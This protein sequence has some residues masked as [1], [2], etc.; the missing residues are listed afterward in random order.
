MISGKMR[1][2]LIGAG[3]IA[4]TY[5]Q[6]FAQSNT[7][8]LVGVVDVREDAA[9]T[10]AERMHC[11]A[12]SSYE[13]MCAATGCE[14]AIVS[15]PPVTHPEICCWLLDRDIHVL[16]EKP[17]AIGPTEAQAMVAAAEQSQATLKMASKFRHVSDVVEAKAIV[18]SGIIGDI[19]LFENAFTSRVDMSSRW[20]SDPTVAGGGV[21]IDN[22]TH[23]VDIMRYFLGPIVEIQVVEG[24]RVQDIPV[25]DTVRVFVR[26]AAGAMGTIDLSWSLNKEL[27]YYLSIYGSSGTLHVGWKESKFRRA[28]DAD[29]TV[30]GRGYDKVQAF[31]GKLDN[32]VRSIRG[33]EPSRIS[34]QDALASVEV[35][36]AAYDAMWRSTWAPVATELS[37]SAERDLIMQFRIHP[38]AIIEE[39]VALGAGTSV[40]D[41]AHIRH[42]AR[43]GEQCIVGGKSYIA[44]DVWIGNRVKINAMA[45]I[46]NAVTIED[47]VMI[48]AGVIFT[49][50]RFPRAATNDLKQLRPSAPDEHT[51][52]TRV[53]EGATIG[54]GA[55]IGND[56]SIGRFA[57]V[58]MGSI[59][60][61]SVPDFHLVIG[62]PARSIG[63]VCRCGEPLAKWPE[64][65]SNMDRLVTCSSCG[66]SFR[67]CNQVVSEVV[68][69]QGARAAG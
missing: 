43:L 48:S 14:A 9:Q 4:H 1:F 42:G 61:R 21:L 64:E 34:L 65:P 15:T 17:L 63:C 3:A 11:R 49:N 46:C 22:G 60:T 13:E 36:N 37:E 38:T 40:W 28:G 68:I 8:E 66:L 10:L 16:C 41:N 55:I 27:P 62:N 58:G 47:G 39:G 56:L 29:W 50:D 31:G 19:V 35:I 25:E 33:L 52:P 18:A 24:R 2:G 32:F 7:A 53:C 5:G 45:Y 67:I 51:L 26:S 54:G 30:F 6:A 44:Y 12:F 23:S 69:E 20:N 57:M 59:V